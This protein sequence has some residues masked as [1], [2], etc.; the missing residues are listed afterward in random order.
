MKETP[1]SATDK[2]ALTVEEE[3]PTGP[4]A[5][6]TFIYYFSTAAFI[7]A[8]VTAKTLGVGVTTGIPGEVA[9][10]GGAIGGALGVAFNRSKV[11]EVSF[12][13]K[14]KFRQQMSRALSDMRYY[15]AS[16]DGTISRYQKPNASRFFA[17]DIYVQERDQSM[18]F[19]SRAGN[20]RT[21]EKRLKQ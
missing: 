16:S 17:G 1:D 20:I 5:A 3:L 7:T 6:F 2:T 21:L 11:L 15:L 19:V 14:K 4:G 12:T 18:V 8:L 9:L 13:S 10:L